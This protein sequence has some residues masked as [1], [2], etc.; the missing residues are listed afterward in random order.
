M[1]SHL[2][3]QSLDNIDVCIDKSPEVI[4]SVYNLILKHLLA[5]RGALIVIMVFYI[6]IYIRGNNVFSDF[7]H[8][9]LS[10]MSRV[11]L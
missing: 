8:S 1:V 9:C 10:I 11:S 5:P 4:D 7:E 6:Y 3:C 2:A